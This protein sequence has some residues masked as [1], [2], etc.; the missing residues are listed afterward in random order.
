MLNN[1][2]FNAKTEYVYIKKQV[3]AIKHIT[4]ANIQPT[5]FN[6]NINRCGSGL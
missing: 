2:A 5:I 6:E 4:S 3:K 1:N